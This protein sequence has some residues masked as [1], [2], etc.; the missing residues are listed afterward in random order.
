[1][2]MKNILMGLIILGGLIRTDSGAEALLKKEV[3]VY[4]HTNQLIHEKSP[5][6][7]QHAHN[8][9]DWVPWGEEAFE[10]A[11][12]EDNP[13]FLSIGYATC[14][15]CHVMEHESF[16][17]EDTAARLNE[18]F[19]CIK[20]DREERPDID[21]IYMTVC[22]MLT[23]SGGWPLTIVITPDKKPFFAATYIPRESRFGHAG[24]LDLIPRIS[25][26]WK[27][28]RAEILQSAQQIS[29]AL[30]QTQETGEPL[31]ENVLSRA[32]QDAKQSFDSEWGGFGAVPKFPSPHRLVFLIRQN[33]VAA[34]PLVEK[35]LTSIRMGGIW[36]QLGFGIHRYSTDREWLVP[37]F[38]KMLY[39]QALMALACVEAYQAY[40]DE[41]YR[42]MADE[43][44]T[45][46]LRDLTA[47]E[48]GF[49]SAEDA[50]S[51]GIEGKFYVWTL[52]ELRSVLT[53]DELELAVTTFN[54][55]PDGNFRAEAADHKTGENILHAN[56]PREDPA[57]LE[58][59]RRKLFTVRETRIHPFKDTKVLTDWNGLMIAA[60][61]K[62]A[63]VFDE[64]RYATAAQRA[65]DFLWDNLQQE[66]RLTHRWRDGHTAVPGQLDDYAFLIF[67]WMELYETTFD[68]QN[69]EKAVALNETVLTHFQDEVRGGFY[70]TADDAE[71][72][73]IRPKSLYDGAIPSGNSVQLMNL[74]K[75]ARLTGRTEYESLADQLLHSFAS[76]LNQSPSGFSQAL[77]AV[78]FAQGVTSEIVIAGDRQSPATQALIRAV[79]S[80]YLTNQTVLFKDPSVS[81]LERLAPFTSDLSPV[82]G[83]P[84]VYICRNFSCE[85]PLTVPSAVITLLSG[86]KNHNEKMDDNDFAGGTHP[87][88]HSTA[89]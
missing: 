87:R 12:E 6:L 47:P 33:P 39:D 70:L 43:I 86:G 71:K 34:R 30:T 5:Y 15:W 10:K 62:A 57:E 74:L 78:Q 16:K 51:E 1:M 21:E 26:A 49:Y 83:Q 22:Q 72:L 11:R 82:N 60:L 29:T 69:L 44:F 23:G 46:V 65:T 76:S 68:V 59:V 75:L 73:L 28:Q 58:A 9:V 79:R 36:D 53:P 56:S 19:V 54:V 37:H 67:G 2:L 66:G 18:A 3:P 61:A 24:L 35:T 52:A 64:P 63:R 17:D 42:R 88:R 8:P 31:G 7:L 50:D 20:V 77:Q 38:E 89:V 45:Y 40:G 4:T 85:Q 41:R 84:A 27:T 55:H 80:V 32:F 14:H 81:A 25:K 13:I 48:G